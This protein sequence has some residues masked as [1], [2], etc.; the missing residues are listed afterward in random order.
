MRPVGSDAVQQD[1][2]ASWGAI[3]QLRPQEAEKFRGNREISEPS[4]ANNAKVC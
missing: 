1:S 4:L 3:A 2:S